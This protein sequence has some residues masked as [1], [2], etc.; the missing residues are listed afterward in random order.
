[1]VLQ[2]QVE[3][4]GQPRDLKELLHQYPHLLAHRER[5]TERYF[6]AYIPRAGE[7]PPP[8]EPPSKEDADA[9][10]AAAAAGA[11]AAAAPK[12]VE[13]IAQWEEAKCWMGGA[14]A[15]LLSYVLTST[16]WLGEDD[17]EPDEY[18]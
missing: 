15:L 5:I 2:W 11:A 18:D 14:G 7:I 3:A 6:K 1:M 9:A 4:P 16:D 12:S 8:T 13:E 10:A 17:E